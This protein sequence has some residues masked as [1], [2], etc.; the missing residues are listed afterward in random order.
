M[1]LVPVAQHLA[2]RFVDGGGVG[3]LLGNVRV[4]KH[5][6]R[7]FLVP[8][9]VLAPDAVAEIVVISHG[10]W[11]RRYFTASCRLGIRAC[12]ITVRVSSSPIRQLADASPGISRWDAKSTSIN[13]TRADGNGTTSPSRTMLCT[14]RSMVSSISASTC[15]SVVPSA[16]QPGRSG[17][18]APKP[19]AVF[20]MTTR[21]FKARCHRQDRRAFAG[22]EGSQVGAEPR[23]PAKRCRCRTSP[24]AGTAGDG[25]AS[26]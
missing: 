16:T 5:D 7:A 14:C 19:S 10:Y 15:F 13:A 24:D 3:E 22:C 9:G 8:V 26:G 17:S 20:S 1:F 21:Y 23:R 2:K 18:Q 6:V 11:P 4:Q 25:L 12:V